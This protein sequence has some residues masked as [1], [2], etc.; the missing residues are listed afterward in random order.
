MFL[1]F[2]N[3]VVFQENEEAGQDEDD[4]DFDGEEDFDGEHDWSDQ[5]LIVK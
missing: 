5:V 1:W 3:L 2:L 4:S